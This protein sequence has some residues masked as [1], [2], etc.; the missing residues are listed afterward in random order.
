MDQQ[1]GDR[2]SNR[3]TM[4]WT[5]VR[6]RN[7]L[8]AFRGARGVS[9][10]GACMLVLLI[11]R[12][13]VGQD[14]VVV[15]PGAYVRYWLP[16]ISRP[17]EA[18]VISWGVDRMRARVAETGDTL[19]LALSG[20]SRLEV[21]RGPEP[22]GEAGAA[23]GLFGGAIVGSFK[24]EHG[25]RSSGTYQ[26]DVIR[27]YLFA[28]VCAAVGWLIGSRVHRYHWQDVALR[29]DAYAQLEGTRVAKIQKA[30]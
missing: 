10:L 28:V 23:V 21:R 13:G 8:R 25:S 30:P 18:E 15:S 16:E 14:S 1:T 3:L 24:F 26:G 7:A 29:P 2:L 9:T 17:T 11:S 27:A 4:K 22:Q 19:D 20:L 5:T 6:S 12:P